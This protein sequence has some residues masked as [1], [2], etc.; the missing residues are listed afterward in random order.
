MLGLIT[1]SKRLIISKLMR[2]FLK[3]LQ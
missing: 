3:Q 2:P 1:L